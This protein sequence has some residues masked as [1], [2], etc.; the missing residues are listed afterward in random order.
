MFSLGCVFFAARQWRRQFFKKKEDKRW[1][2]EMTGAENEAGAFIVGFLVLQT[3]SLCVTGK[4]PSLHDD[5]CEAKQLA[6][7]ASCLWVIG[8]ALFIALAVV[9]CIRARVVKP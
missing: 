8:F 9:S 5:T 2:E 1:I 7:Q 3:S 6:V 4:Q